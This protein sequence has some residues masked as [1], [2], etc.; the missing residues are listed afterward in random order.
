M[1]SRATSV[2]KNTE[3]MKLFRV[4]HFF[5]LNY[6]NYLI[7]TRQRLTSKTKNTNELNHY[8]I[9]CETRITTESILQDHTGKQRIGV[10]STSIDCFGIYDGLKDKE[11]SEKSG[12]SS[13]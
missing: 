12:E 5:L 11:S 10:H 6:L 3:A 9:V 8:A 1:P 7:I 2:E 4:L 13:T